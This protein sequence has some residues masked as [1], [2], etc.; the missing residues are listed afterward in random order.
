[1]SLK[2]K[3]ESD[4][5]D[6]MRSQDKDRLRALRSIKS[7]ILLAESEKGAPDNLS[8]ETE[9]NLLNKLVKQRKESADMYHEQ[10]REDLAGPEEADAKVIQ[11]Y[12]PESMS[13]EELESK[14]KQ[15]I[16]DEGAST[17]KDMGKVMGRASK[18]L[19][20][21]ADNKIISE[22]VKSLLS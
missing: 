18:E 2:E 20:G 13:E 22:K 17:M 6:A 19:A 14:I 3:I 4:M 12:L 1:M 10:G 9:F 16:E 7:A 5:K 15:I 11:E 8:E 21:K